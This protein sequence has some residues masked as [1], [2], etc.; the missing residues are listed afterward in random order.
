M[1]AIVQRYLDISMTQGGA[2]TFV[3]GSVDTDILPENGLAFLVKAIEFYN[4]QNWATIGTD[5]YVQWSLSR[6]TKAAIC[7]PTDADCMSYDATYNGLTTSGTWSWPA[8]FAYVPTSGLYIV[9]PTIYGQLASAG[10]GQAQSG[11][12]RIYYDEV[13]LSEVEI[14]RVLNN[15]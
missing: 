14:L 7:Q 6:D 8:R 5:F 1:A 4:F 12:F 3:Q 11:M 2:D 13:K 15:R 10:S 9:E